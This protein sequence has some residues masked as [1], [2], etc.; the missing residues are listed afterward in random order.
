MA[1][2][3]Q[4]THLTEKEGQEQGSNM[5]PIDIRIGHNDDTVVA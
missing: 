3:D 2:V 1:A 4:F 5:G